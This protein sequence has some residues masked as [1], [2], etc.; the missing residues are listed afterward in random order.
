VAAVPHGRRPVRVRDLPAAGRPVTLIWVK[1]VWRCVEPRC[2]ARTWSEASEIMTSNEFQPQPAEPA[3]TRQVVAPTSVAVVTW[4]PG[5]NLPPLLAAGSLLA[6]RGH[7]VHVLDS[8]A[9][10]RWAESAGFETHAYGRGP[11]PDTEVAFERQAETMMAIKAG[12]EIARDVC[13]MLVDTGARLAVVDCMLPA[14]L[15]AG[16]ATDTPTA[17]LVHFPYGLARRQLAAGRSWT[18]DLHGLD[19]T[20]RAFGL[21]PVADALTAERQPIW[22]WSPRRNGLTSSSTT[23]LTWSTPGRSA[24]EPGE[25]HLVPGRRTSC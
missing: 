10:R 11:E 14:G 20:H 22:C 16:K 1:R 9:T 19:A 3:P 4:A 8:A 18:S 25:R 17:S 6:A 24:F 13:E 23:R 7:R 2:S 5:G 21:Q 15:A 12:P